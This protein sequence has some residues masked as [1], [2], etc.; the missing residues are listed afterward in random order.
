MDDVYPQKEMWR[1][2]RTSLWNREEDVF[3]QNLSE[4]R[5][6]V[7]TSTQMFIIHYFMEETSEERKSDLVLE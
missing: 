4:R 3:H 2:G 1:L 6:I 5:E 7:Q